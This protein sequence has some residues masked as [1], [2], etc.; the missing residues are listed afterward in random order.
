MCQ[1]KIEIS[2]HFQSI[3]HSPISAICSILL[4][5]DGEKVFRRKGERER[6]KKDHQKVL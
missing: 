2:M 5:A 1:G 6:E 3:C 4:Q